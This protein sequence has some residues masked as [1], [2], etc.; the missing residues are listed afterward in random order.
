MQRYK[1]WDE[2][3]TVLP[4]DVRKTCEGA[5]VVYPDAKKPCGF[6]FAGLFR[7]LPIVVV[8]TLG[9]GLFRIAKYRFRIISSVI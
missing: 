6:F 3:K 8:G 7:M 9:W 1:F 2:I 5:R 4:L